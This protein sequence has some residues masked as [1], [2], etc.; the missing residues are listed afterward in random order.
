MA[1]GTFGP[2]YK[3][4]SVVSTALLS[5]YP[6]SQFNNQAFPAP[7]SPRSRNT[8]NT[9]SGMY[10]SARLLSDSAHP[11]SNLR[12]HVYKRLEY[13]LG[14][15][16]KGRLGILYLLDSEVS[17]LIVMTGLAISGGVD[18]MALASICNGFTKHLT[19]VHER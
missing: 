2:P 19:R 10:Y 6:S 7:E 3:T 18:S 5:L 8:M 16:P 12:R 14:V 11:I 15:A 1:H 13:Q 9:K 4:M 17:K